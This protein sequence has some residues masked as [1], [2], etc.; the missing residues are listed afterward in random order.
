MS[1]DEHEYE[2][3]SDAEEEDELEAER[4][5][6][7]NDQAIQLETLKREYYSLLKDVPLTSASQQFIIAIIFL[8]I[9]I[10]VFWLIST[11]NYDHFLY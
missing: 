3:L 6:I 2:Y 9:L 8:F 4:K 11:Q 1:S 5:A 7:I 10:F